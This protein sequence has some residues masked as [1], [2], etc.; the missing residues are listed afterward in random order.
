[1][2]S[3]SI[4]VNQHC[5]CQG[6]MGMEQGHMGMEQG[7]MGMEQGQMGMGHGTSMSDTLL[8]NDISK[9]IIGEVH[10]YNFYQKLAE[11]A[12]NER[13]RQVIL[14][15]QQDEAKHYHWFTMILRRMGAQQP[16]IPAGELPRSFEEG[17]RTAIQ[18]ELEAASFYQ[19]IAQRATDHH[20]QMHFMH[21][22]HDEQRHATWFMYMLMNLQNK[23][24]YI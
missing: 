12:T 18:D 5:N 19:D 3:N 15:I 6:H 7:H 21:A 13:D 14:R 2:Y 16:Q 8:I 20:I 4:N 22:S 11:L 23:S 9:A 10:A 1:M 17:V 24:S